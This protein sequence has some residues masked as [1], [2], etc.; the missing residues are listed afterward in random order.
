M[1]SESNSSGL[2]LARRRNKMSQ[3]FINTYSGKRFDYIEQNPENVCI[4]DIAYSLSRLCRF[5]G[6]IKIFY[7]VCHH[8]MALSDLFSSVRMKIL[9]F[10]HDAHEIYLNDMPSPAVSWINILD[11]GHF[12]ESLKKAKHILDKTIFEHLEID[13]PSNQ[14]RKMVKSAEDI[15]FNIEKSA[16]GFGDRINLAKC[17]ES[18]GHYLIIDKET[19]RQEYLERF[20]LLR[21]LL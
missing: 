3:I 10:L 11:G 16:F 19:A 13:F 7:T 5:C 17:S 15:L 14:E 4:E 20:N 6:H 18:L 2:R 21:K 9:A 12:K 1:S 8:S